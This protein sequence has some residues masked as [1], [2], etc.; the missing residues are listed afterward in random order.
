MWSPWTNVSASPKLTLETG[1]FESGSEHRSFASFGP[2]VRLT[3]DAH[4]V[5][6]F[7]D[8]GISPTLINGSQYGQND[9]GTS[10]NFTAHVALGLRFG[11][12]KSQVVKLRY[13]HISNGG[14]NNINP[15][16]NMVGI[17][18]SFSVR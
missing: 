4:R 3:S 5:P 10:F 9:F 13:Q 7:V 14:I 12:T 6:L 1:R 16:V 11:P 17:D 2:S 18:F 15:G 8:L